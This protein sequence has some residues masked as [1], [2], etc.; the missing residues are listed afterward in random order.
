[1]VGFVLFVVFSCCC[2]LPAIAADRPPIEVP[3]S[4]RHANYSQQGSCAYAAA[5]TLLALHGKDSLA[6]WV[7]AHYAGGVVPGPSRQWPSLIGLAESLGVPYDF[8]TSDGKTVDGHWLQCVS[9]RRLGAV[10]HW[11]GYDRRGCLDWGNHAVCFLGFDADGYAWI[12]DENYPETY[13]R[14]PRAE[15]LWIWQMSGGDAFTFVFPQE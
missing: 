6:R 15:F 3:V 11:A 10:I 14:L 7:A 8:A 12:L 2:C 5:E 1:L 13:Q 9:D 4:L